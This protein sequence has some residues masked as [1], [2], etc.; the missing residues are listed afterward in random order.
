LKKRKIKRKEKGKKKKRKKEKERKR[1]KRKKIII[2]AFEVG[3]RNALLSQ[4]ATQVLATDA[5][6]EFPNKDSCAAR[7][8][9]L[10]IY[11]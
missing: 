7:Q 3:L 10:Q 1:K 6:P 8:S 5:R 2:L 9:A 11:N 4:S